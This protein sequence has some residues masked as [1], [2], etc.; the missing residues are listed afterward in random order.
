MKRVVR[1]RDGRCLVSEQSRQIMHVQRSRFT[2]MN[3]ERRAPIFLPLSFVGA[4]YGRALAATE[5]VYATG[6]K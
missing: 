6:S 1:L 2:L 3:N 5:S 4:M